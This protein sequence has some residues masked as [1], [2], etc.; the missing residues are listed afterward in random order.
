MRYYRVAIQASD[1]ASWKW[2]STPL[3]SLEA[4][5]QLLR[6]YRA[7]PQGHLR[8]FMASSRQEMDAMLAQENNGVATTSVT[9]EQFLSQRRI[10][11]LG[12]TH[13]GSRGSTHEQQSRRVS[14]IALP[15]LV[16]QS[17][18][19]EALLQE[20]GLSALERRRLELEMGEGGDHNQPYTFALPVLVPQLLA[21]TRLLIRVQHGELLP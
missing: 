6:L 11:S 1:E 19:A 17:T 16:A 15:P 12:S 7:L 21:W 10:C 5:F 14:T 9:A 18:P 8:V 2:K 13:E 4:L 20:Q 3:A